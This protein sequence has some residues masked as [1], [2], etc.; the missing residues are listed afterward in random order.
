[1]FTV[2][3]LCVAFFTL[4]HNNVCFRCFLRLMEIWLVKEAMDAVVCSVPAAAI[5][6]AHLQ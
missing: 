4:N 1:M 6:V 5:L 3:F 2:M